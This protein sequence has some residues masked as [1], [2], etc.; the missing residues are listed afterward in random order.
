[1]PVHVAAKILHMRYYDDGVDVDRPLHEMTEPY[2]CH[3]LVVVTDDGVGHLEGLTDFAGF[4]SA[5]IFREMMAALKP[6]GVSKL[7]Y[8]HKGKERFLEL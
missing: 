8:R 2:Y 5:K 3:T 7:K 1:M 6:Y 4:N